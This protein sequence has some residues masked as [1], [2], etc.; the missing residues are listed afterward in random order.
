MSELER[1]ESS[2]AVGTS[3]LGYVHCS[4]TRVVEIFGPPDSGADCKT[5][6]EWVLKDS[7]GQIVTLYDYRRKPSRANAIHKWHVGGTDQATEAVRTLCARLGS[8]F[9]SWAEAMEAS[10][11]ARAAARRRR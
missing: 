1:V 4:L 11:R 9:T 3:L 6:C 2:C 7:H 10:L 5:S 8:S